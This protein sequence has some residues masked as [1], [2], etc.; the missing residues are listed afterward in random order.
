MSIGQL[1]KIYKDLKENLDSCK[2]NTAK[3]FGV[4]KTDL[5]SEWIHGLSIIRNICAHH[6]RLWN[7]SIPVNMFSWNKTQPINNFLSKSLITNYPSNPNKLYAPICCIQYLLDIIEPSNNFRDKLKT[8]F[9]KHPFV[10]EKNMGFPRNW[11]REQF[12]NK[13]F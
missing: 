13:V 8:L 10:D 11:D 3:S 7:K 1:S 4:N 12:W 9:Q 5:F 2:I 6:G